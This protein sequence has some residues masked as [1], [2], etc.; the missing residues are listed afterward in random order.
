MST[1]FGVPSPNSFA[2]SSGGQAINA[3]VVSG[4]VVSGIN[5]TDPSVALWL[6]A[7]GNGD[8]TGVPGCPSREVYDYAYQV[9]LQY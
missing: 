1:E 2:D 9:Y 5:W 4:G 6:R 3:A 8:P 7:V